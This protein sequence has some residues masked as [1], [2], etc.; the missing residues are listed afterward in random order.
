MRGHRI[1]TAEGTDPHPSLSAAKDALIINLEL[2]LP[3]V[4]IGAIALTVILIL[5][6]KHRKKKHMNKQNPQV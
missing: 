1:A 2:A 3:F 5:V 4:I 6:R